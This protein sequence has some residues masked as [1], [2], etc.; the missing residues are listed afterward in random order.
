MVI[1]AIGLA[2]M[3]GAWAFLGWPSWLGG[4]GGAS[5]PDAAAPGPTTSAATPTTA[6]A[7]APPSAPVTAAGPTTLAV[8]PR[9]TGAKPGPGNTGVPAG[10][11]LTVVTGDQTYSTAGQVVTGLDIHGFVKVTARN[12]TIRDSVIYSITAEE[13]PAVRQRLTARL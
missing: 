12:V 2:V 13:W 3:L 5:G 7:G 8:P 11:P 6:V 1:G 9:A 10:T 4:P